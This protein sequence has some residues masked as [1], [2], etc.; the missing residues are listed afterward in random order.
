MCMC[1][2]TKWL[3]SAVQCSAII[4]FP[5]SRKRN[6]LADPNYVRVGVEIFCEFQSLQIG[7][8]IIIVRR[9]VFAQYFFSWYFSHHIFFL[10]NMYFAVEKLTWLTK[11]S[12]IISYF[13]DI[14]DS[15]IKYSWIL[16]NYLLLGTVFVK[17][18]ICKL[19]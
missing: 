8:G 3:W 4:F 10:T 15:K 7:R 14:F 2:A 11:F 6:R 13:K 17:L 16:W 18:Q 5:A 19:K 1:I 9:E 12:G